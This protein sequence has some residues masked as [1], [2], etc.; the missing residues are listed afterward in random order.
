MD[1]YN[2]FSDLES[3]GFFDIILPFLLVFTISFA[4]I[5]KTKILGARR[6]VDIIVAF[7]IAFL[8]VRNEF[9][10]NLMKSFLPNVAMFMIIILMFLL[11]LGIFA[12]ENKEW[13]GYFWGIGFII[14]LIF[15]L[16]ALL[17]DYT[18]KYVSFPDWLRDMFYSIDERTKG[19]LLFIGALII[20]IWLA[21]R[22]PG[23]GESVLEKILKGPSNGRP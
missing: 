16:F 11:M 4:I 15:I 1:F 22:E 17:F 9:F 23:Q 10:V 19:I 14:S 12:G 20:V 8:S 18:D 6:N 3:M 21:V 7:V 2:I 13:T 5:N